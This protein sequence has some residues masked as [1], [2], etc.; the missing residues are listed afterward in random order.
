MKPSKVYRKLEPKAYTR[1]KF[2]K[3]MPDSLIQKFSMGKLNK[4][5]PIKIKLIV[6]KTG[7]ISDSALE[8]VRMNVNRRLAKEIGPN[9]SFHIHPFPH[10]FS[11]EHGLV[12]IAKA[13]RFVKGMRLGFGKVNRR[14]AR[15]KKGQ[16]VITIGIEDKEN[17][18]IVKNLLRIASSKLPFN[19]KIK[20]E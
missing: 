2:I 20:V 7:Q 1:K 16:T 4:D 3:R 15:V 5:F 18:K 8:S 14:F 17:I 12:G 10:H 13:E 6:Q 11:R 9:Y 19:Y